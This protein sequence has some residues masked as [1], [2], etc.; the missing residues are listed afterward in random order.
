M[1]S[2]GRLAA[3][4]S[5]F[6]VAA[7]TA[8]HL[9]A[10]LLARCDRVYD[11]PMI[12]RVCKIRIV[13]LPIGAAPSWIRQAWVGLELSVVRSARSRAYLTFDVLR[14][15]KSH[16]GDLWDLLRGKARR[17][18]GYPVY[19]GSAVDALAA[20]SPDAA[21]WWRENAPHL[22]RPG[23]MFLFNEDACSP[24]TESPPHEIK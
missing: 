8:V 1:K 15:P 18:T 9:C 17:I 3:W 23:R 6:G 13:Q 7:A 24:L 12:G 22:L 19:A 14:G 5:R 4:A 20:S 21:N 2:V 10:V 11:R 16:L